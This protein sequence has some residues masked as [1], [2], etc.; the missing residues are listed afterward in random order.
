L[1]DT[2]YWM[3]VAI[4]GVGELYGDTQERKRFAFTPYCSHTMLIN[5]LTL[6]EIG[7]ALRAADLTEERKKELLKLQEGY[8]NKTSK[9]QFKAPK[10]NIVWA[11]VRSIRPTDSGGLR[12]NYFSFGHTITGIKTDENGKAVLD[13]NGKTIP[14]FIETKGSLI[15]EYYGK[16]LEYVKVLEGEFAELRED[17]CI[18]HET[19]YEK[20]G[21]VFVHGEGTDMLPGQ[22]FVIKGLPEKKSKEYIENMMFAEKMS[23]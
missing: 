4:I 14:C 15:A 18:A 11:V 1:N 13:L 23:R 12:V 8:L 3:T 19:G 9:P 21:K 7:R 5:M 20:E 16:Q 17:L 10:Q 22:H 6:K 2:T